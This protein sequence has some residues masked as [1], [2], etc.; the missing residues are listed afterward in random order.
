ME[1]MKRLLHTTL[2]LLIIFILFPQKILA[3]SNFTTDSAVTYTVAQ[4][5]STKAEFTITLTSTTEKIYAD[6]YRMTIG[7]NDVTNLTASDQSGKIKTELQKNENNYDVTF[8]LNKKALGLGSKSTFKFAF[9]T[10]SI[11]TKAGESWEISIPGISNPDEFQTFNT[12]VKVP[13]SFGQASYIKPASNSLNFTKEQLQGSGIS[14]AYGKKRTYEYELT[15]HLKNPNLFPAI[16]EIALPPDTNYQKISLI[17]IN[18][19]PKKVT[20]DIDG[21]WIAEY[22]LDATQ[23]LD[24]AVKGLAEIRLTPDT[25]SLT[26]DQKHIYTRSTKYWPTDDEKIIKLAK[27][28]KSPREIYEYVAK[29]LKYDF[30]RVTKNK[31]RLGGAQVLDNPASAVCLEFTDL[32]ITLARAKGIPAREVNGFAY[33]QNSPERPLSLIADVL[34]A[35]PEY[36]DA[37]K[38]SWI[39]V[40]P[41]WA[42]TTDGTD[43]FDVLDFDHFAFV[44]K[45]EK[46]SYPIPAGGYKSLENKKSQDIKIRPI[47]QNIPN[48]QGAEIKVDLKNKYIAGLPLKTKVNI[49]NIGTTALPPQK[50]HVAT[51][52][53]SPGNQELS[54]GAIP[55]FGSETVEVR[56]DSGDFLTNKIGLFTIAYAEKKQSHKVKIV[57]FFK[58]FSNE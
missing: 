42:Q 35:W 1:N 16:T 18:P 29:R 56:F 48:Q 58:L 10:K 45:G 51:N 47:D 55:P 28:L 36:Y 54:F 8:Y 44:I 12:S 17:S 40:D 14:I 23:S 38:K 4:S 22:S 53:L 5:G 9:D 37:D 15:Y 3:S 31:P 2:L 52:S 27:E 57:P 25:T 13:E 50:F 34:H 46:D 26:A 30:T 6:S 41:T 24:V 32:F 39:M 21:N 11:A 19:K 49:V 20:T 43:Y 7:L 33:T